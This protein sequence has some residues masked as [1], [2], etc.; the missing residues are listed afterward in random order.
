[1][2][3]LESLENTIEYQMKTMKIHLH[4]Q[5]L[6]YILALLAREPYTNVH[7]VLEKLSAQA[8]PQYSAG[9][10]AAKKAEEN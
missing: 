4:P 7:Q 5:E 3:R 10:K 2:P 8:L 1:L 9:K 6:E